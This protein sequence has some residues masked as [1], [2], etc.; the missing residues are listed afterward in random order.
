MATLTLPRATGAVQDARSRDGRRR[1]VRG[2]GAGPSTVAGGALER[3]T[4]LRIDAAPRF[5]RGG[6]I[7]RPWSGR[8][9]CGPLDG[10]PVGTR[11]AHRTPGQADPVPADGARAATGN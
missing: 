3:I 2:M 1:D 10:D 4:A 11:S 8:P 9:G 5:A 6:P 7:R